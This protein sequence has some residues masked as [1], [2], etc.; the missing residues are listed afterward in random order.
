[1]NGHLNY[2]PMYLYRPRDSGY[3][4]CFRGKSSSMNFAYQQLTFEKDQ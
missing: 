2:V 1:M 4:K 3:V